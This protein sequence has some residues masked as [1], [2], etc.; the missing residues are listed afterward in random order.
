MDR[1]V[2]SEESEE[3]SMKAKSASWVIV[4]AELVLLAIGFFVVLLRALHL[5]NQLSGRLP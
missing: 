1:Y 2:A 4:V 3:A 5:L